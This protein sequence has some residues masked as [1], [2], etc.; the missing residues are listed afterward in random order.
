MK[1]LQYGR[2]TT[3]P[4]DVQEGK[5][6][7]RKD[8]SVKISSPVGPEMRL[9]CCAVLTE[10]VIADLIHDVLGDI[11]KS[12]GGKTLGKHTE[13]TIYWVYIPSHSGGNTHIPPLRQDDHTG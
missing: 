7:K 6:R 12:G 13:N 2:V 11:Q 5:E 8:R 1:S 10:V 4:K 3:S 9:G